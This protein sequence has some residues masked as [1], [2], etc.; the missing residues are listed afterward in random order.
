MNIEI[1]TYR[2]FKKSQSGGIECTQKTILKQPIIDE[3]FNLIGA[4]IFLLLIWTAMRCNELRNLKINSLRVDGKPLDIAK[5]TIKQIQE[6]CRFELQRTVYKTTDEP[7][8]EE[9][10]LPL[11]KIGALA[12]ATLVEL[13]RGTRERQKTEYLL[14]AGGF[15]IHSGGSIG[16][17]GTDIPINNKTIQKWLSNFCEFVG[18]EHHHPHQ[19]RK[20]LATLIIN[21]DPNSLELIRRILCHDNIKMTL[22]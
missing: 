3:L 20:T 19:C 6:G 15:D 13:F 12:F 8:G 21:H 2:K 5:D 11:T 17:Y 7:E 1:A 16:D 9:H 18:V 22:E 4:S 14:P 10:E